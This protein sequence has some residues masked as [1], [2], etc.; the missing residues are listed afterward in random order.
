MDRAVEGT[1]RGRLVVGPEGLP[2]PQVTGLDQ[3][4]RAAV[5][6][7]GQV[8]QGVA[9]ERLVPD[10]GPELGHGHGTGKD[11][12]PFLGGNG[13]EN[14]PFLAHGQFFQQLLAAD[15]LEIAGYSVDQP[16]PLLVVR[17]DFLD[18]G[19]GKAA[20]GLAAKVDH[21]ANHAHTG[22]IAEHVVRGLGINTADHAEPA[23]VEL[24]KGVAHRAQYPELGPGIFRVPLGHGQTAGADGAPDHHLAV[25]HGVADAVGGIAQHGDLGADIEVAHVVR[26]RPLADDGGAGLAHAAQP[27]AGRAFY[28][29]VVR[30]AFGHQPSADV[31]LAAGLQN[32]IA[33]GSGRALHLFLKLL[34]AQSATVFVKPLHRYCLRSSGLFP[35]CFFTRTH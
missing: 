27:L 32:E 25:G 4:D 10:L 18:I 2:P 16:L 5:Q 7:R 9:A 33:G 35:G 12:G 34:G 14:F 21:A 29:D 17:F 28:S 6:A 20:I 13:H 22:P 26:G 8:A 30:A 23:A 1:G 31:V 3:P 11:Q 19:G 24:G 15:G